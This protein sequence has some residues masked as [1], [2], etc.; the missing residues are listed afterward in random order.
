MCYVAPLVSGSAWLRRERTKDQAAFSAPSAALAARQAV[1]DENIEPAVT[2]V[3]EIFRDQV[4]WLHIQRF[5]IHSFSLGIPEASRP[6][7]GATSLC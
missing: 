2:G 1:L 6:E 4:I 5:F 7:A 3:C